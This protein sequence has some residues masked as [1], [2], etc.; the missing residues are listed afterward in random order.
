MKNKEQI[1]EQ[2]TERKIVCDGAF[3]TYYA[4][5]YDTRELP[6]KANVS[7]PER[8]L[9]IHREYLKAG[10]KLIRTNTY[11]C[12]T[13][14]LQTDMD[15]VKE[16]IRKGFMLAVMAVDSFE[17]ENEP[18][19]KNT[20]QDILVA[21]D[22]GP[23]P[24]DNVSEREQISQE[25]IEICKTFLGLGA[26]YIVFETFSN[27][28][29]IGPALEFLK[30][31]AFVQV[32]FSVNQFGY[33][34]AGLSARRLME[35]AGKDT[36]V[37][38]TGF[39]CGVGPGHL[40]QII[41]KLEVPRDKF[42]VALPNAGYPQTVSN[43]MVFS[44]QNLDYFADKVKEIA[45]EGADIVGGCCG[46]TPEHI[47]R[48][49]RDFVL[50]K[51]E[52]H[53]SAPAPDKQNVTP[54]DHSFFTHRKGK[55]LIA[56]E[57]APPLGSDDEKL[58][59]AAHLLQ[60]SGVDVLTFPDS[61]SGRTRADS[62]LMADKV[63]KETGISVMPH[64][65]CRDKNIIAMRSQLLGA[66]MN[67]I[68]NFLVIT[69]DPI[70]S[71][72]RASIKSVFQFDSVGMMKMMEDMNQDQFAKSPL[73]Y[74]GAINQTRRNLEVE[75]G[76]VKKKM[77]AGASFFLTQPISTREGAERVRRIKQETGARILCGIMPFVSLK[78]ALFMKN[79]MTGIDV[80][81][82]VL[83]RYQEGMSREEGE[84]A[85]VALAREV[86]AMTEDYADGYYFSF[87]F[88]RVYLLEKI[89]AK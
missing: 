81:Q 57:L 49:C 87:P 62:I 42:F 72:A 78:N 27:L 50:Y 60:K 5:K 61:P 71:M 76:R 65:C 23:I 67:Q 41:R 31:K 54:E 58:M 59:E 70:P 45:E 69:G 14:M 83:A 43:R 51:E 63:A 3:G 18:E 39:N 53:F 34:N 48:I 84:A 4:A 37:D 79:E 82:E 47:R 80:T 85:G 38:A 19:N 88:N 56:V 24:Y 55:K 86:I 74:G 10:A 30:G 66:Y 40:Q 33:S 12:N 8:V 9:E 77:E 21:A 7:Y 68:Y 11:A 29:E 35:E 52:R 2:L 44:S 28:E 89:L 26:T 46:S 17:G 6:E 13:V 36:R 25:Y 64:I 15:C 16:T 73:C 32:Q 75:I 1:I 22:I 20:E